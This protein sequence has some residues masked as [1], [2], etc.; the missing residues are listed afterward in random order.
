MQRHDRIAW[1]D[2][3]VQHRGGAHRREQ[4]HRRLRC[5]G[6]Q[7]GYA[8]RS[9]R[10]CRKQNERCVTG[11]QDRY[12]A[13]EIGRGTVHHAQPQYMPDPL[14]RTDRPAR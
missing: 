4:Q 11:Q 9:R 7:F 13:S 6:G 10:L 8:A 2:R 14:A 12:A 5:Q 1:L 3:A